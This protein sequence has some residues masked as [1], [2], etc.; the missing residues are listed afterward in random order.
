MSDTTATTKKQELAVTDKRFYEPL[1]SDWLAQS[2]LAEG[3]FMKEV[4]FAVQ[5]IHRNPYL[6]NCTKVSVLR[7]VTNLAQVGLT[8]NPVLKFAYLIPRYNS[9]SKELE[10]VLEPDYRGLIKLLTDSGAVTSIQANII[11]EGDQCLIDMADPNFV[12]EH[13]PYFMTGKGKGNT[14]AAY[15]LAT[16][17]DKSKHFEGMSFADILEIRD[18]SESYKAYLDKKIP[19]C[20]WVTDLHEMCRKTVIKRHSKYL[21]KSNGMERFEKA[22]ALDNE[23]HGFREAMDFGLQNYVESLIHNSTLDAEK[24]LK[25]EQQLYNLEYKD[26]AFK[27][28]DMLKDCQP[29]PGRDYTPHTVKEQ[30]EAIRNA[31]D[32]DDFK[33]RKK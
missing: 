29:V 18:R 28:I 4:S 17:K 14:I 27:M 7:A 3:E 12:K 25:L 24:K 1:K 6:L 23:V 13:I 21:P 20:T 30:G 5:H 16:L 31:V 22:V 8:L 15:S 26:Q 19:T 33:E 2:G 9:K 11:H 10:C 32:L